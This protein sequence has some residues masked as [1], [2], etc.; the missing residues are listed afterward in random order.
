MRVPTHGRGKCGMHEIIHYKRL[1]VNACVNVIERYITATPN[2]RLF[3]L[4]EDRN[5]KTKSHFG[6]L[7]IALLDILIFMGWLN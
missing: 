5:V 1:V 2:Q 6:P 3:C 4:L 7:P